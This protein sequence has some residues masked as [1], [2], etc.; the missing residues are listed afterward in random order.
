MSIYVDG[1][2]TIDE[3]IRAL[4]MAGATVKFDGAAPSDDTRIGISRMEVDEYAAAGALGREGWR[5][6]DDEDPEPL[7]SAGLSDFVTAVATGDSLSAYALA[8]RVFEHDRNLT[9][10]EMTLR[11]TRRLM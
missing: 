4:K 2:I 5:F 9:A 3:V 11:Q 7:D 1:I 8:A 6:A 10:V